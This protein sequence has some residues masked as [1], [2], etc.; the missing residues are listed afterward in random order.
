MKD[1][2]HLKIDGG[3]DLVGRLDDENLKACVTE[4]FGHFE[5]D[6]TA[7]HDDCALRALVTDH[8]ADVVRVG[9]GP[10]R[11]DPGRVDAGDRRTEG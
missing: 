3:H 11:E 5:A 10:K 4:V 7:A 6:E 2:R 9:N 8:R 1:H